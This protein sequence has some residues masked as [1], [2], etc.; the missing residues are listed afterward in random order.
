[1]R[2]KSLVK[3]IRAMAAAVLFSTMCVSMAYA[4]MMNPSGFED[5]D[6]P[7]EP[8]DIGVEGGLSQLFWSGNNVGWTKYGDV[9]KYRVTLYRDEEKIVMKYV[10]SQTR[11]DM[12]PYL[13]GSGQFYVTVEV[14][15]GWGWSKPYVSK[16]RTTMDGLYG[17]QRAR[18]Q[19]KEI[20]QAKS[21]KLQAMTAEEAAA[22]AE[23][24]AAK[25]AAEEGQWLQ[26]EDGT[27]RWWYRYGDG[28]YPASDWKKI[29]GKQYYFDE[30]GWMV[31]G[32][33]EIE[34]LTYEFDENGVWINNK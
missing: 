10:V 4:G 25:K 26:A 17:K 5:D 30:E 16:V 3:S 14:E 9:S 7:G 18:E 23:A 34:G 28:S 33:Q 8:V 31:T 32:T 22:E 2:K 21:S 15:T 24:E 13:V 27:G 11:L 12:T 19:A 29:D 20:A 6:Y 1:M